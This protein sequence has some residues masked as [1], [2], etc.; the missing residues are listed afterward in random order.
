VSLELT[1]LVESEGALLFVQPPQTSINVRDAVN[2][3]YL[4]FKK[5]A[6]K[7]TTNVSVANACCAAASQPLVLNRDENRRIGFAY[8]VGNCETRS[9]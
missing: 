8:L 9:I 7:M 5:L 1:A 2:D 4:R 6:L 3:M